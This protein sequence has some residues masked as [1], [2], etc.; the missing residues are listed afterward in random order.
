MQTPEEV[1]TFTTSCAERLPLLHLILRASPKQ[2]I[3]KVLEFLTNVPDL[4]KLSS[5]VCSDGRTAGQYNR[6][7]AQAILCEAAKSDSNLRTVLVL[8]NADTMVDDP[9]SGFSP[10]R[11][12]AKE[13]SVEVIKALI[14]HGASVDHCNSTKETSLFIA[15]QHKQ[16]KAAKSL[17]DNG[18]NVF[19]KN[20][21]GTSTLTVANENH[22][23]EFFAIYGRKG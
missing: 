6:K 20:A 5:N 18:E 10:L 11:L 3:Q 15:C 23:V 13:G 9:E 1:S 16:W 4:F 2:P 14:K 8:I 21:D 12:A 7:Q 17:Y 19:M 22:G